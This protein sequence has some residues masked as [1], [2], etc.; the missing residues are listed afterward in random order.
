MTNKLLSY[1]TSVNKAMQE[2][3]P[4]EQQNNANKGLYGM[5]AKELHL[6]PPRSSS[7][8]IHNEYSFV[9]LFLN[10]HNIYYLFRHIL[11]VMCLFFTYFPDV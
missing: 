4:G 6:D 7:V 5:V 2:K 3:P 9:I 11:Y 1:V 10:T 8:S